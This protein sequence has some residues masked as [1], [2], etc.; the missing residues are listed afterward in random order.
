MGR[1]SPT[2]GKASR[3]LDDSRSILLGDN[4]DVRRRGRIPT[5]PW[6]RD[7]SILAFRT[8]IDNAAQ[9]LKNF[10]ESKSG[11]RGGRKVGFPRSKDR[12][13]RKSVT[14]VELAKGVDH[15]HWLNPGTREHVR[16]MLPQRAGDD[17]WERRHTRPR[18]QQASGRNRRHELA[19]LHTHQPAAVREL[20]QLCDTARGRVQALTIKHEGGRWKAVFRLR[21]LDGRAGLRNPGEPVRHHGGAIGVGLGLKHLNTLDRPIPGLTDEHGH[22]P[23]PRVLERHLARLRRLDRAIAGAR[24]ARRTGPSCCAGARRCTDASPRPASWCC[25]SCP[26]AWRAGS[27]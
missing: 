9:A 12:H 19:W 1:V 26:G 14:F 23:N 18:S 25:T 11:Q 3:L 2:P 24:S 22:V 6:H 27:T 7:V 10:A 4:R 21:L 17:T 13:S 16:L 15:R 20:W 8:G 5:H